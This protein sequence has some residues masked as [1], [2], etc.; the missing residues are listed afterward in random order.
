MKR[1]VIQPGYDL[2]ISFQDNVT[3][4]IFF[5]NIQMLAHGKY[6]ICDFFG[7]TIGSGTRSRGPD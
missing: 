2:Y 1:S 3:H 5:T 4:T 7:E 6:I